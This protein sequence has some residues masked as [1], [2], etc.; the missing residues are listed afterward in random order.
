MDTGAQINLVRDGLFS[1]K[2]VRKRLQFASADGSSMK[3]GDKVQTLS[4][5]LH[6]P[7]TQGEPLPDAPTNSFDLKDRFWNADIRADI[8]LSYPS[9]LRYNLGVLPHRGCLVR[10]PAPDTFQLL[11][12]GRPSERVQT[13]PDEEGP[14][15]KNVSALEWHRIV[16]THHQP[17]GLDPARTAPPPWDPPSLD[18]TA[19]IHQERQL[20]R[21]TPQRGTTT[22]SPWSN[23]T[24]WDCLAPRRQRTRVP[25]QQSEV[26]L[27]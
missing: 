3:G 16:A 5:T 19:V 22:G 8:I 9:L 23:P 14:T 1:M 15:V 18:V 27:P 7:K 26:V 17:A 11:G 12:D 24:Q 13:R 25:G 2:D 20:D 21:K 10:E 4:L 6:P